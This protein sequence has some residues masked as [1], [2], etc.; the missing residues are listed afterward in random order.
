MKRR[1][2]SIEPWSTVDY[3]TCAIGRRM[4]HFRQQFY[5]FTKRG[6]YPSANVAVAYVKLQL[7][8]SNMPEPGKPIDTGEI[9]GIKNG[10]SAE[11]IWRVWRMEELRS[12]CREATKDLPE[13]VKELHLPGGDYYV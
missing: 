12:G 4:Y 1:S 11:G 2:N 10:E 6:F 3:R 13:L 7:D 9:F 8:D 5:N